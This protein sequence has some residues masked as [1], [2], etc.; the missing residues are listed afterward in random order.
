M[1]RF[2]LDTDHLTLHERGHP[3]LCG[4]LAVL[5]P[6]SVAIGA[7]SVEESLRGRLAVLAR[8][9]DGAARVRAYAKLLETVQF[10]ATIPVIPYDSACEAQYDRLRSLGLRVG[11]QDLKIA[12]TA[13][14]NDVIVVTRNR[15]DFG[16][17][18]GLLIDDWS[19]GQ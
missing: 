9:L 13:L 12:A 11:S 19:V 1:I 2:L 15:R 10:F 5:P 16:R 4:R 18:P 17:V 3:P 6:D 8:R 7:V 14:A